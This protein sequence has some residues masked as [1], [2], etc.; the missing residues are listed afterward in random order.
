MGSPLVSWATAPYAEALLL[1]LFSYFI[2]YPFVEYIRDPK[3]LRMFPN[4]SP[5]SVITSIPF[6]ILAHSGDRSRRLAKLH[7][8]R[9]ILRTRPNTLSFGTVRAIKD[10]YGHGTPC[11]KDESYALPA[12]THYHL[13]DVVDKGDHARKR[14]VLSSAYAVKNL[15]SWEYKVAD[16]VE[17]MIG[18]FDRRCAALPQKDG[19]F[20]APEELDID[21]LPHSTDRVGA[22]C[23]D[24]SAYKT[25]L[26]E[27]LYPTTRKQS[28]LIWSYGWDKLIDKMVNAIPFYRRM[29]ESS[30]G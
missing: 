10:I 2:V 11:L 22:Q 18:Q 27:C 24:G 5:F 17:R 23:K 26:R 25:N 9:P 12:G 14:K 29:A 3:G 20:A 30:R 16:K 1:S 8:G 13:A 19:T 4:F 6:T 21:Y 15:E 7:K 28:F